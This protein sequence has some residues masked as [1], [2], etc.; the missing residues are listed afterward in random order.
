MTEFR[1]QEPPTTVKLEL[2][3]GCNLRCP[4]C[5]IAGIQEKQAQGFSFATVDTIQSVV[6]QMARAGWNSR[7]ELA[8][9][10]EPSLNPD[11]VQI[12][13]VIRTYLPRA[14]IMMTSNGAG[15]LPRHT[16]V[17]KLRAAFEYGLNILALD[18]YKD[19]R[20]VPKIRDAL[21]EA[22]APL[23][24]KVWE[25]PD[26]Q[27]GNPHR[28][29]KFNEHDLCFLTDI[30]DASKGTHARLN[31]GGGQA[32]PPNDRMAG[33]RCAR[34]F[35]ELSVR[36]DGNAAICC[37]D[38][39]GRYRCGSVTRDGLQIVWQSAAMNAARQKLIRGQRDFGPCRGCDSFSYRVG[40]LPDP[41][42]KAKLP[43]PDAWTDE[44]I[45]AALAGD[46][47]TP[48]VRR[49]WEETT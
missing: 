32:A 22:N 33:K 47:Y 4:F 35:R 19:A 42:G 21:R 11:F 15:F 48:V 9:H 28:R 36:W 31:N 39:S 26:Q 20:I 12:I 5:G 7:I 17:A 16:T 40:L 1:K 2:T 27:E 10:G 13:S 23:P 3:Q 6:E 41:M 25:Y 14:S 46:P 30:R 43:E 24:F 29:R 37:N 44:T 18:D 34:V 8:M 38:W 45:T 49:P